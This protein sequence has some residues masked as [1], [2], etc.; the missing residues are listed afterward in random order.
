MADPPGQHSPREV[1]V[2]RVHALFASVVLVASLS[3]GCAPTSAD[4]QQPRTMVPPDASGNYPSRAQIVQA[5]RTGAARKRWYII[6]EEPSAMIATVTSGGHSATV[7][8]EYNERGWAV[9]HLESSP[10]LKY[11]PDY[12]GREIIHHR[13]NLWVRQLSAAIEKALLELRAALPPAP[14]VTSGGAEATSS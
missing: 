2:S 8:I 14:A 6:R 10:G 1:I 13:Y 11:D 4:L 5:I 9:L 7:R 12:R 3:G